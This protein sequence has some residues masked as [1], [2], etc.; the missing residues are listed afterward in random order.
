MMKHI[1]LTLVALVAFGVC[2]VDAKGDKKGDK[3]SKKQIATV[4]VDTVPNTLFSYAYGMANTQGF[5]N[6]LAMRLGVDTTKMAAFMR[7]FDGSTDNDD[8]IATL[9]AYVA[10]ADIRRQIEQEVCKGI[11]Q[12]L[13]GN[14]TTIIVESQRFVEGF[15]DALTHRA[16]ISMD[17][18]IHAVDKNSEYYTTRMM[19]ERFG[20][21]KRENEQFLA[22]NAKK[23]SI[24]VLPSG[25][26]YKVLTMGDGAVP[27][28]IDRV[29]VHY[30]GKLIDGT[31]FDSSYKRGQPATFGCQQVIK[32]W[33]EVLTMMPVGSKWE[34]YIPQELAYGT[35]EQGKIKP[36]SALVF[37]IELITIEK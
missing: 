30:E 10:G 6:Y 7:G 28:A 12:R 3:K 5:T 17:S 16:A 2:T 4:V 15:R 37:T 8:F 35:R 26:Q 19:E 22:D 20:D 11:N 33:T 27:A 36:F 18:A 13:T 23:D 31:V 29:K 21:W 32:G 34:V 1:I 14:D 24:K 9:K 25:V